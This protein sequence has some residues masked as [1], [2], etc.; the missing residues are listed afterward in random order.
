[1]VRHFTSFLQLNYS[2]DAN[3][4][5]LGSRTMKYNPKLWNMRRRLPGFT[6]LHPMMAQLEGGA[7]CVTGALQCLY[8]AENLLC[9]LTGMK[10]FT[11]QPGGRANGI[12]SASS[13]F[14]ALPST[15]PRSTATPHPRCGAHGT[16]LLLCGLCRV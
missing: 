1:M 11:F 8:E 13:S 5:P 4:Y 3:F 9:E 6:R 15:W 2:V 16:N 10:A 12:Q 14:A 7:D